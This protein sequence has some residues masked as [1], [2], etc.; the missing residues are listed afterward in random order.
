MGR[1]AQK[2]TVLFLSNDSKNIS[3]LIPIYLQ[4]ILIFHLILNLISKH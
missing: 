4:L 3:G 2:Y 1:N